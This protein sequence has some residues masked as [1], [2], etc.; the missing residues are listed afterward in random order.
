ML[1]H[2]F[3]VR[4]AHSAYT[5]DELG[6]P[7]SQKGLADAKRVSDILEKE[8]IDVI[9][10]SP[11]QRAIQT[12][13][14]VAKTRRKEIILEEAFKERTLSVKPV[15]DFPFAIAKVWEEPTFAWDG[16]ESNVIAQK[17][18]VQGLLNTLDKYEGQH[19]VIATHGNILTLIMNFF[20]EKYDVHFWETLDMPDV[21]HVTFEQKKLEAVNRLWYRQAIKEERN[22]Q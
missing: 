22:E 7:L 18:G 2:V 3:F 12:V 9:I 20:N 1:T 5:P 16:G 11:Y 17:R 19:I 10:S 21:Y 6:R 13:E 14:K 8:K 4:H 15:K